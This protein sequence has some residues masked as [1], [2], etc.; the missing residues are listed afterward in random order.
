M[1]FTGHPRN[2]TN[3]SQLVLIL[4][5]IQIQKDPLKY[6]SMTFHRNRGHSFNGQVS[7]GKL[8]SSST[9]HFQESTGTSA[10]QP[11]FRSVPTAR[12]LAPLLSL[13]N[14]VQQFLSDQAPQGKSGD[15]LLVSQDVQLLLILCEKP[16]EAEVLSNNRKKLFQ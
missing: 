16:L 4:N 12:A 5:E 8:S 1:L 3:S 11:F 6:I 14:A 13:V 10:A 7:L 9:H 15:M 2:R